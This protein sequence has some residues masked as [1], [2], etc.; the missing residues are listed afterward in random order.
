MSMKMNQLENALKT[1]RKDLK[2]IQSQVN[3]KAIASTK[4]EAS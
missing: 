3:E 2:D 1:L 4:Q